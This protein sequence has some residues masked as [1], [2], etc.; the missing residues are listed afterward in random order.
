MVLLVLWLWL[1][2]QEGALRG[3]PSGKAFGA[4]YAMF[5]TAAQVLA[6]GGNPYDHALLYRTERS[7]LVSQHLSILKAKSTVR[8]GNP[9]LLFWAMRPLV[10]LPF[11]PT[12]L[13]WILFLCAATAGGFL[14]LLHY[15]GWQTW[16][17]PV[18]AFM[19]VPQVVMGPFYG[20]VVS[21][22]FAAISFALLTMRRYPLLSGALLSVAWLKPATALPITLLIC[23]F[24]THDRRRVVIGFVGTSMILL[25]FTIGVLGWDRLTQWVIGL[26]GYSRDIGISPDMA[27]FAGLYIRTVPHVLRPGIEV[28]GVCIALISTA[29][30]WRRYRRCQA[31]VL[32]VAWLWFL[33][34]LATPFAHFY[35]EV[36]LTVPLLAL[37]GRNGTW[38]ARSEA[39]WGLYLVLGSLLLISVAPHGIQ[40]LWLP[41]LAATLCLY[42]ASRSPRYVPEVNLLRPVAPSPVFARQSE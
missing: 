26:L 11:Q 9:P 34:F 21:I 42:L 10:G 6:D 40:L 20:N 13:A 8:V 1:F 28:L 16:L 33:W 38:I 24:H 3:G 19:L 39:A 17:V 2:I 27:S 12:A 31:P 14:A 23:L 4:D 22:E 25:L 41:L 15:M 32:A 5:V 37:V 36:L 30:V 18:T 7:T 29:L 35:D